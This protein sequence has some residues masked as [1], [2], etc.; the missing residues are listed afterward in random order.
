MKETSSPLAPQQRQLRLWRGMRS[1]THFLCRFEPR[2]SGSRQHGAPVV[3]GAGRML[4][5][6]AAAVMRAL[7]LLRGSCLAL[8]STWGRCCCCSPCPRET[9][10]AVA[11]AAVAAVPSA[12]PRTAC[13]APAAAAAAPPAA[14]ARPG[15]SAFLGAGGNTRQQQMKPPCPTQVP[16]GSFNKTSLY[17]PLPQ[18]SDSEGSAA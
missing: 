17:A 9:R 12:A 5:S 7:A 4:T 11:S 13:G 2:A 14:S 15:C 1:A 16:H 8:L 10:G 18:P 3:T 6:G